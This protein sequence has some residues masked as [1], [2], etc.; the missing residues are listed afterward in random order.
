MVLAFNFYNNTI[1]TTFRKSV[2]QG[3]E[4]F[5]RCNLSGLT[6]AQIMFCGFRGFLLL[7]RNIVHT[8]Y[9]TKLTSTKFDPREK[10][11]KISEMRK[12]K[13]ES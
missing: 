3:M 5:N 7:L 6:F 1:N 11:G 8:K 10:S 4:L 2:E 12:W 9:C 13:V